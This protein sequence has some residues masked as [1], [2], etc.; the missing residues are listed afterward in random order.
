MLAEAIAEE[1]N[2]KPKQILKLI[3]RKQVPQD[4]NP[5]CQ[6]Q[7]GENNNNNDTD[8]EDGK[9]EAQIL[10]SIRNIKSTK[11]QKG[12]I[13]TLDDLEKF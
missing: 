8:E 1:P 2:K 4:E 9:T 5:N 3:R 11:N 10:Q 7:D 13:V 6:D 12:E